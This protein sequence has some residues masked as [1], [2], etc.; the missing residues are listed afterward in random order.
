MYLQFGRQTTKSL[1]LFLIFPVWMPVGSNGSN[2]NPDAIKVT[3][4][5]YYDEDPRVEVT[6]PVVEVE[7][8]TDHTIVVQAKTLGTLRISPITLDTEL[9]QIV[10][11]NVTISKANR[12]PETLTF[13][14]ENQKVGQSY[15]SV[16]NQPNT[17]IPWSYQVEVV[18]MA[19][20]PNKPI[21]YTGPINDKVG[22][23]PLVV[24]LPDPPKN[25]IKKINKLLGV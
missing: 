24:S 19:K 3:K 11:V 7:T 21:R 12:Q 18:V 14:F 20:F 16:T 6:E 5:V 22:S 10:E 13:N 2:V 9:P 1:S 25:L 8:V 15:L 17:S 4:T 23:G